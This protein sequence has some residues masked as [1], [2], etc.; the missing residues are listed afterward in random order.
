[1]NSERWGNF[2]S[3]VPSSCGPI[4]ISNMDLCAQ[5]YESGYSG[6]AWQVKI[7]L[8]IFWTYDRYLCVNIS[9]LT[10]HYQFS[11]LWHLFRSSFVL[12]VMSL[13]FFLVWLLTIRKWVK[14]NSYSGQQ[15]MISLS[16]HVYSCLPGARKGCMVFVMFM[17][18]FFQGLGLL[19]F[20]AGTG[21]V[22]I[23]E[24]YL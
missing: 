23:Q 8:T 12:L 21:K 6:E 7:L 1:M 3:G 14:I 4:A 9:T 2:Q 22:R 5:N 11:Q 24:L 19:V 15:L 17:M 20:F 13:G 10:Y 18:T 16:L